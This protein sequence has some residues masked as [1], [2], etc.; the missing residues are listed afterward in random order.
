[1]PHST[2]AGGGAAA[3]RR[4]EISPSAAIAAPRAPFLE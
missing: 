1:M 4:R 3:A 2:P